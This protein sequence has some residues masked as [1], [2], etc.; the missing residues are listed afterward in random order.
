MN[1]NLI[2]QDTEA[3]LEFLRKLF[4]SKPKFELNWKY[5]SNYMKQYLEEEELKKYYNFI[6]LT[7]Y[8]YFKELKVFGDP[9]KFSNTERGYAIWNNP[10]LEEGKNIWIDKLLLEDNVEKENLIDLIITDRDEEKN[11]KKLDINHIVFLKGYFNIE[12]FKEYDWTTYQDRYTIIKN[13][14]PRISI[15]EEDGRIMVH[16]MCI[17]VLRVIIYLVILIWKNQIKTLEEARERYLVYLFAVLPPKYTRTK[18]NFFFDEQ[19]NI[20]I[21]KQLIYYRRTKDIDDIKPFYSDERTK[22]ENEEIYNN[23]KEYI[24][25][26]ASLVNLP[27]EERKDII[28]KRWKKL[29]KETKGNYIDKELITE[30]TKEISPRQTKFLQKLFVQSI[31]SNKIKV[32]DFLLN[33]GI[34]VNSSLPLNLACEYGHI[35]IAK[36]LLDRKFKYDKELANDLASSNGHFE[37]VSLLNHQAINKLK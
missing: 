21:K 10:T 35:D 37:I 14:Y 1:D 5:D 34:Q 25:E 6:T 13:F 36:L 7:P 31:S 20:N 19:F 30:N 18:Q 28:K 11:I 12:S 26:F 9:D 29:V 22:E 27:E 24:K 32:V 16:S 3:I 15:N 4:K 33:K 2:N 17:Q 23:A 8:S